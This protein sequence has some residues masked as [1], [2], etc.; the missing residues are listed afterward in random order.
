MD[1]GA[2]LIHPASNAPKSG[3]PIHLFTTQRNKQTPRAT[4]NRYHRGPHQL[5]LRR[6]AIDHRFTT[7]QPPVKLDAAEHVEWSVLS[8][9][10]VEAVRMRL[11]DERTQRFG[12][13]DGG[14]QTATCPCESARLS[15]DGPKQLGGTCALVR[16]HSRLCHWHCSRSHFLLFLH[17]FFF[18]LSFFLSFFLLS[19]KTISWPLLPDS[20]RFPRIR[21]IKNLEH[22]FPPIG[23]QHS[24]RNI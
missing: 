11:L 23:I 10:F 2:T 7:A 17:R 4:L 22:L 18:F 24:A 16:P 20:F 1:G 6:S 8:G 15:C 21:R 5:F 13:L 9:W 19:F 12:G 3:P 14:P